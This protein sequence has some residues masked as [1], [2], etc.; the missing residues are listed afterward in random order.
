MLVL[1]DSGSFASFISSALASHLT[2]VSPIQ[3]NSEVRVVGGG[4]A[5]SSHMSAIAVVY[6]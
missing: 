6:W 1:I 5:Q 3:T 2:G 4:S